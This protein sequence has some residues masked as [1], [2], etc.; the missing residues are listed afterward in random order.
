[1]T[2]KE[3]QAEL[4]RQIPLSQALGAV[5]ANVDAARAEIRAP[6]SI[7][8]NHHGTV[9][10]G[11]LNAILLLSCYCWLLNTL[12]TRKLP[13][14]VVIKG[15]QIQYIYPVPADFSAHCLAPPLEQIEFF[16]T[17]LER[18]KKAQIELQASVT[19]TTGQVACRF[20]GQFVAL[21]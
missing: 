16:L 6:L 10:G 21:P 20:Q 3:L 14:K 12:S 8:S 1:M 4:H 19:L 9:F 15:S 13:F 5:V 2:A 18:K 7:N 11:S 17:A